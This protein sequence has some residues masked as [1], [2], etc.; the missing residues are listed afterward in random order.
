MCSEYLSSEVV[1]DCSKDWLIFTPWTLWIEIVTNQNLQN[2]N[3]K[4][5]GLC[6][7]SLVHHM[8]LGEE[9][10]ELP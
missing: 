9:A 8:S 4:W 3:E 6:K 2:Q 5:K 7:V 10:L 1:R